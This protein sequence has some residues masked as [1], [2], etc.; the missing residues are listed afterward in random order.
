MVKI[1]WKLV[2]G[3]LIGI[4]YG[5]YLGYIFHESIKELKEN[6]DEFFAKLIRQITGEKQDEEEKDK[7][8]K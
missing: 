2:A 3:I 5:V 1:D 4:G 6:P 8:N 7:E